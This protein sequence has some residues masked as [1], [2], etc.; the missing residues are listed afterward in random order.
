MA[1]L[2]ELY[3]SKYESAKGLLF[4]SFGIGLA[5]V[6]VCSGIG[7]YLVLRLSERLDALA[8]RPGQPRGRMWSKIAFISV[9]IF[10]LILSYSSYGV[11]RHSL[12]YWT[13]TNDIEESMC[14]MWERRGH[15]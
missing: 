15:V 10:G 8:W 12:K 3:N 6:G 1:S 9:I 2:Q 11:L 4:S 13:T 5:A 14:Q 7:F